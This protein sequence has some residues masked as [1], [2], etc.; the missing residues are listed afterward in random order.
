LGCGP[1]LDQPEGWVIVVCATA[2]ATM[3]SRSFDTRAGVL[4]AFLA[5]GAVA[6]IAMALVDWDSAWGAIGRVLGDD[7]VVVVGS[8][9]LLVTFVGG[10]AI[11]ALLRPLAAGFDRGE[12]EQ[13]RVH[14]GLYIGWLERALLYGFMVAGAPGAAALIVAAKSI[15]RF[16]S[17]KDERFAEYY[18]IGTLASVLVAA[19]AAVAARALLGLGPLVK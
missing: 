14:A 11:G 17:F 9:A 8:G 1:L 15:A 6:A 7:G 16:P 19:A 3:V 18:L 2:G 13:K 10:A 12:D 5:L 4:R